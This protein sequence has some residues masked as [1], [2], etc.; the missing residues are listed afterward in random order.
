MTIYYLYVKTHKKTGLKYLGQTKKDPVTYKGSGLDW[1]THIRQ[2]GYDVD[3]EVLLTTDN[4]QERNDWGR[5]YSKLWNVVGGQDD[6][7]NKI[8][9]NRIPETGG[10][11]VEGVRQSPEH[12]AKRVAKNTGKKRSTEFRENRKGEKNSFYDQTH[13]EET[14]QKMRENHADVSGSKNP[15]FG[16]K[17]KD[18]PNFGKT[19]KWSKNKDK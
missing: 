16:K 3:T 4:K 17:G 10:S 1:I 14:K 13:K 19:W 11:W 12:I 9:A 15:M 7:G 8:W 2:Y 18:H 6:Y 5:Y